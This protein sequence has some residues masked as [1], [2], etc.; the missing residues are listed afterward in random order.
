MDNSLFVENTPIAFIASFII[1]VFLLWRIKPDSFHQIS[2]HSF[3]IA[4]AIFWGI[5]ATALISLTWSFYYKYFVPD[6]YQFI[7]PIGAVIL[8]AILGLVFRWAAIHLPGNP[9]LWFCI[10]GGLESIPEHAVG[11]YRFNIL[12]I[13]MLAG[14]SAISIFIFAF[15]EYVIYWGIVLILAVGVDRV[16]KSIKKSWS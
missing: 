3:A 14:S 4:S 8:Y 9:T 10:L 2:W 6:W 5:L 13:P 7:G 15:F 16:I 1:L 11:I 12:E